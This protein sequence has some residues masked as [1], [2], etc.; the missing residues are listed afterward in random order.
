MGTPVLVGVAAPV[1]AVGLRRALPP[2][3]VV[4]GQAPAAAALLVVELQKLVEPAM[5]CR[6]R[7]AAVFRQRRQETGTTLIAT[8]NK[9]PRDENY[10]Q[11]VK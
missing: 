2:P 4:P 3:L 7:A 9:V 11:H 10:S 8:P 5:Q 1:A 6:S